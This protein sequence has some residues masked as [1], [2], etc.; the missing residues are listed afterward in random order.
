MS[1][2][3]CCLSMEYAIGDGTFIADGKMSHR[4][5]LGLGSWGFT[6]CPFCGEKLEVVESKKG[7]L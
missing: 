4:V 6:F 3:H 2:K 5:G 7:D 1:D